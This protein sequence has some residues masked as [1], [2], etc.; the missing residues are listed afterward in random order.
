M[1]LT[2]EQLKRFD[3]QF[4]D[5]DAMDGWKT[6]YLYTK[7]YDQYPQIEEIKNFLST[8]IAEHY[9][10]LEEF[11]KAKSFDD[12]TYGTVVKLDDLLDFISKNK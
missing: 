7:D 9:Q 8:C 10:Q 2:K 5:P 4:H 1:S 11:I 12:P 6:V 3:E